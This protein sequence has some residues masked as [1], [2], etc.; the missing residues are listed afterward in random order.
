MEVRNFLNV[1]KEYNIPEDTKIIADT[2]WKCGT[3]DI[4]AIFYNKEKSYIELIQNETM[5]LNQHIGEYLIYINKEFIDK[6]SFDCTYNTVGEFVPNKELLG[7]FVWKEI[8]YAVLDENNQVIVKP[9]EE[10]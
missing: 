6:D 5:Y 9:L 4:E 2:N 3:I 10:K 7:T 8:G 1:L